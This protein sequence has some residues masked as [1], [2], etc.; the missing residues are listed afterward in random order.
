MK[1]TPLRAL[2]GG[3]VF[4]FLLFWIGWGRV[5][6]KVRFTLPADG[7]VTLRVTTQSGHPVRNLAV[8]QSFGKGA[9][10]VFWDG[11]DDAGQ[12]VGPDLYRW[13]GVWHTGL[14]AKLRGWVGPED[15]LKAWPELGG[16]P[17]AVCADDERVYLGW[18]DVKQGAMVATCD[19]DGKLI[20]SWGLGEAGGCQALAVDGGVVYVLGGREGEDAKGGNLIKLESNTGKRLSWKNGEDLKVISLWPADSQAKPARAEGMGARSGRVYLTF[21]TLHFLAILDSQSGEYLSTVVGPSPGLIDVVPTRTESVEQPGQLIDADFAVVALQGGVIGKVLFAHDPFW[22]MLSEMQPLDRDEQISALALIGDGAKQHQHSIFVGLS[23]PFHQ[24][25]RRSVIDQEGFSWLA[26]AA[27]GRPDTGPWQ[28]DSLREIRGVALDAQGRLWVAERD[29]W[30][31]RFSVWSTDG[32]QG[33]LLKEIFAGFPADGAGVAVL[34]TEPE[35]M[36]AAGCEWRIDPATGRAQCVGVVA[37]ERWDAARFE[38]S[39]EGRV[40]LLVNDGSLLKIYDRL[41]PG[42]YERRQAEPTN[43]AK[44]ESE[45]R[46]AAGQGTARIFPAADGWSLVDAR[47]LTL[48]KLFTGEQKEGSVAP[49][50]DITHF[51]AG[52]AGSVCQAA[53]GRVYLGTIKKVAWN[54]EVIGLENVRKLPGGKLAFPKY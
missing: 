38:V 2:F 47:G 40:R 46:L 42:V 32:N 31:G 43:P 26:G 13:E 48:G 11:K 33:R 49:G 36:A 45:V 53:D 10:E 18:T 54:A 16:V 5:D 34:P 35:V 23:A 50:A 52:P 9:H 44:P 17:S 3:A 1:M 24:L 22:V 27:G 15:P 8:A 7:V 29:R 12:K 6:Q 14:A 39:P 28:K 20:W 41:S 19:L 37:R 4:V 51:S 25:Q 30:P 21:P